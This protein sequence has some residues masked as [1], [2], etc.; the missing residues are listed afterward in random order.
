MGEPTL[1]VIA[2]ELVAS[3]KRSVWRGAMDKR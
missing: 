2:T 1:R 3:I